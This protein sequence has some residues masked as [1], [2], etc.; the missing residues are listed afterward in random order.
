MK[1]AAELAKPFFISII[2][3]L[4]GDEA[5]TAE[6]IRNRYKETGIEYYAA[7][8][9]L[10]PQGNDTYDK[11][12]IQK[13]S[14]RILKSL[15]KDDKDIKLGILFQTT[16]GHGGNW[17]LT[18]QNTFEANKILKSD[19]TPTH[20][21]CP[22]DSRLLDYISKCVTMLCEEHP[23]F[24]FGDDDMRMFEDT[25]YCD[26]HVKLVSQMT[27][28]NFNRETLAAAVANAKPYDPVA[29]AWEK[30][31]IEAIRRL[32]ETIRKAIDAVD[33]TL[34]CGSCLVSNRMDYAE[35]ETLTLAGNTKPFMRISNATYLEG[36][37]KECIWNDAITG[38]QAVWFKDKGF[39]LLDESD[40]CP[41]NRYSKSARTMHTHITAGLLRG[42]DGGKI[43]LDQGERYRDISRPYEKIFEENQYFYRRIL[44]I[45]RSWRPA[46]C[47][48]YV[49]EI[50]REPYPARGLKF[51]WSCEW[52]NYC[53]TRNG[54]PV[55]YENEM[56]SDIHLLNGKQLD[57]YNDDELKKLLSGRVLIDG[58][59]A[60]RLTERGFA[61]YIGVTAKMSN[62]TGNK[63]VL[64]NS[65]F[66]ALFLPSEN[67][68]FLTLQSNAEELSE[69]IFCQYR[70]AAA[71][72]VMPGS[73]YFEN[74]L[75]GKVVVCAME[76]SVWHQMHVV[77][78]CRKQIYNSWLKK[79]GGVV[80][81]S[82]EMQDS[83]MICGTD[84]DGALVCALFNSSY[85]PLPVN[86]TVNK[87]PQEV[88]QL[89]KN[90]E[91][92]KVDFTVS[93]E[94]IEIAQ[95]L[96]PA[97]VYVYKLL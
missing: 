10:H 19:G 73:A 82:P 83:R 64:K 86:L 55:Y 56:T 63:E 80:C 65:E 54:Y 78:P 75:G 88:M 5:Y 50:D 67:A 37:L 27:D 20:R 85:D 58:P 42:L 3:N 84:T 60:V 24:A 49:P 90:G 91:F 1:T 53:F 34:R 74:S 41:H 47:A 40:T 12:N 46:G 72:K 51:Y 68:P 21:C 30:S 62:V 92:E 93:G 43:W 2:P 4:Q 81:Y 48:V 71:A 38:V 96:Q 9:P 45:R 16:L 57:Y 7:S 32:C 87:I 13:A 26:N 69:V 44:D 8:Y 35:T 33:P 77:N 39:E 95:E 97:E 66:T 31:Q 29:K 14:F 28:I 52:S 11:V 61:E 25:C 79:L 17:N 15:L 76:L 23:D 22:L 36:P 89:K 59:G 18:P 6:L 70:G 94:T